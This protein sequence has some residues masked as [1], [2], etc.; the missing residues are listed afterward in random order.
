MAKYGSIFERLVARRSLSNWGKRAHRAGT[1]SLDELRTHRRNARKLRSHLEEVLVT[2]SDRLAIPHIGSNAFQKP[3]GTDWSWRPDAWRVANGI[4]GIA[5]APTGTQLASNAT[6]FHDCLHSEL[7][8]R[9][10]R[11]TREQD[12]APFGLQLDVFRFDGSFL[13]VV[14]DLPET[15]FKGIK[16]THLMRM[17]VIAEVERP[18]EIF[19][20]LNIKHGPNTEQVVRELPLH[21]NDVWVEFD[22]AYTEMNEK[23]VEKMWVDLIFEGPQN[24]QVTMR[25]VTFSRSHRAEL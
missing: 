1:M 14:L 21:E 16:K 23:R 8:L 24:N 13:S 10:I 12:L 2:A 25:D 6:L 15:A 19:V 18:L 20:R 5:G 4:K 9:Q 11:N 22:L 7:T 3:K 17:N